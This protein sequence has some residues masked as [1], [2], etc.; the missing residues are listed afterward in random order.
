MNKTLYKVSLLSLKIMPW[1]LAIIYLIGTLFASCGIDL[2]VFSAIGYMSV[3][4]TCFIIL[5]SYTFSFCIWHRIPLYFILINNIINWI[6]W[7][8][9][10]ALSLGI[11]ITTILMTIGVIAIIGAYLKNK[12]N[13]K[14]RTSKELSSTGD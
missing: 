11:V 5:M 8:S 13:E 7:V 1:V 9:V 4:P 10:G 3:I 2:I 14:I 6:I 12:Y